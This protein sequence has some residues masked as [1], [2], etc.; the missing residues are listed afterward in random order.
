MEG[1][2]IAKEC[3]D[4]MLTQDE[5]TPSFNLDEIE[6]ILNAI[7]NK[8][9]LK[10]LIKCKKGIEKPT[11]TIKQL[12][13]TQ[14]RYYARLSELIKRGLVEK[15]DESY[16]LTTLG[17]VVYDIGIK[18]NTAL[19]NRKQFDLADRLR[20]SKYISLEETKKII[21]ALSSK[22]ILGYFGESNNINPIKMVDNLE[23]VVQEL[24]TKIDQAKESVY[25][26]SSYTDARVIQAVLR[27]IK[28]NVKFA[29]ISNNNNFLKK[30][31]LFR[32]IFSPQMI[33]DL[34]DIT[35][36]KEIRMKQ[37]NI[38]YSFCV[39]DREVAMIELPNESHNIFYTG[40]IIENK[41]LSEKLIETFEAFYNKGKE[42]Q[43]L[44]YLIKLQKI[45]ENIP[46]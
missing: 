15:K 31:Q 38:Q 43:S 12:G 28:R 20:K 29:L 16:Y 32:I 36:S 35:S 25:L 14:R 41:I 17:E 3:S 6:V 39:I 40:F 10:I 18:F 9:A 4:S 23:D 1:Y 30:I 2:Y 21:N 7:S 8:D 27:T 24:V 11:K 34:I 42:D 13:L 44:G 22:G 37:F 26:A 19:I 33:Q 46:I 5:T 45:V